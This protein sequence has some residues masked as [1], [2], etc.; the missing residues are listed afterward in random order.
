MYNRCVGDTIDTP[1][2]RAALADYRELLERGYPER[3]LLE[4]VGNRYALSR[5]QRV[6]LT[7]GV[8]RRTQARSRRRK[9]RRLGRGQRLR[10][11]GFNVLFTLSSYLLGKSLFIGTDGYLRDAAEDHGKARGADLV[12]KTVTLMLQTVLDAG[13]RSLDLYLDAPVSHSG[14]TARLLRERMEQKGIP[15]DVVVA[16]SADYRLKEA[17]DGV[18]ATSDSAVIDATALGVV[19]LAR[20]A[21]VRRYRARF[22][23]L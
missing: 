4:L 7:R 10:V 14:E 9:L 20:A 16:Q 15:G 5:D 1:A 22:L 3:S 23:R 21:L 17:A 11:D 2:F 12:D 6:V 19:D 18:L 13:V 8:C